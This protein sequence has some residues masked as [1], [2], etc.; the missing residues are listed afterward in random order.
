MNVSSG[1]PACGW[2]AAAGLPDS[3][4]ARL[5]SATVR[6]KRAIDP[7]LISAAQSC[8]S[9]SSRSSTTLAISVRAGVVPAAVRRP[10]RQRRTAER[11]TLS[12]ITSTVTVA[13]LTMS[14][15]GARSLP[16]AMAPMRAP[17]SLLT[18][19]T[20]RRSGTPTSTMGSLCSTS[21]SPVMTPAVSMPT[22]MRTGLPE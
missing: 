6:R 16:A 19:S 11:T 7:S 14:G 8:S 20:T 17:S 4:K 5:T 2:A 13:P 12:A 3:S 22:S 9:S 10:L 21:L 15:C 18:A 1:F